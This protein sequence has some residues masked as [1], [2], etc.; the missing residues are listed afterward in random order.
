MASKLGGIEGRS[1]AKKNRRLSNMVLEKTRA[2]HRRRQSSIDMDELFV[3]KRTMSKTLELKGN[4]R[5]RTARSARGQDEGKES[6]VDAETALEMMGKRFN[7]KFKTVR[8]AFRLIDVDHDGH[9][10][11]GELRRTMKDMNINVTDS[12]FQKILKRFKAGQDGK[13]VIDYEEFRRVFGEQICGPVYASF[14]DR[15]KRRSPLEKR[16]A[17]RKFVDA[18]TARKQISVHLESHFK[19][20]RKAFRHFDTDFDGSF[21]VDELK[22]ALVEYNIH[23]TDQEFRKL[24]AKMGLEERGQIHF[25]AFR[26]LFGET[27]CGPVYTS[28][29]DHHKRRSSLENRQ[30]THS[31]DARTASKMFCRA[32]HTHFRTVREAFRHFDVDFDNSLTRQELRRAFEGYNIHT[33]DSVFDRIIGRMLGSKDRIDYEDF[34]RLFGKHIDNLASSPVPRGRRGSYL[35]AKRGRGRRLSQ[36]V[37]AAAGKSRLSPRRRVGSVLSQEIE[38]VESK[39]SSSSSRPRTAARRSSTATRRSSTTSRRPATARAAASSKAG[40]SADIRSKLAGGVWKTLRREMASRARELA[41]EQPSRNVQGLPV[42]DFCALLRRHVRGISRLQA[43]SIADMY[44]L[45]T[46]KFGV[47]VEYN[48]LIRSIVSSK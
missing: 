23:V 10:S 48:R 7:T 38:D 34:Q 25:E 45:S 43:R 46:K 41:K 5:P 24:V 1:Y 13:S 17:P 22:S 36:V 30:A 32:L 44:P 42:K 19:S 40:L 3:S 21:S 4:L 39:A 11:F 31:I 15:H 6:F 26:N 28:L 16:N 35:Y 33:T 18:E 37:L 8:R 20:V 47:E 9:I 29:E 14:E 12:D 27:I 2:A